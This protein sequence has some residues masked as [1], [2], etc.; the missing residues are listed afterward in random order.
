MEFFNPNSNLHFVRYG[1]YTVGLA[2][3]LTV[4]ALF[5]IFGRG[6]NYGLEFTGGVMVEVSYQES[7]NTTDVRD[8]LDKAG[9]GG[10]MVQSVGGTRDVVVRIQPDDINSKPAG[11]TTEQASRIAD[12]V[13]DALVTARPD[14]TLKR[15]SFVGPQV[16]K[17]L[18]NKGVVAVIFV[19]IGIGIYLGIRFER[20]FA[21]AVLGN[22]IHDALVTVGIIA[23]FGREFDMA[24]LASVLAV[25]G[26]SVNDT[27]VVF[28]RVRELFRISRKTEP[29]HILDRAV[30]NTLSRTIITSLT[31]FISMLV[32]Y[33]VG[34]PATQGFAITMMV[35]VF[36]GT[37][38]SIFIASPLLLWLGVTKQDM[39]K[40]KK[41]DPALARRP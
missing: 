20:K 18:R 3:L 25:V 19:M 32:L 7:I 24:V 2:V 41:D 29:E 17:Q 16:G 21:I 37:L 27:V 5:I 15:H 26:Y 12:E 30:N 11:D 33:L 31:T 36:L 35:G 39:L 22:L 13:L 28:D 8:A 40:I 4:A 10:A 6:L 38:S 34:G 9:F 1:K 14:V 23:L